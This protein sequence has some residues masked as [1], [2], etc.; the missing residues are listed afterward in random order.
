MDEEAAQAELERI[1]SEAGGHP[2]KIVQVGKSE[3]F[4]A[5]DFSHAEIQAG[6]GPGVGSLPSG[7]VSFSTSDELVARQAVEAVLV[8]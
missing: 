1:A 2:K 3:V 4:R 7:L 6:G 5:E 8:E